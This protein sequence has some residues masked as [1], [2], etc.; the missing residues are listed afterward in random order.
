M[1]PKIKNTAMITTTT[2]TTTT[3]MIN[4]KTF[5]GRQ[6]PNTLQSSLPASHQKLVL[7]SRA[8][9]SFRVRLR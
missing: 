5:P 8:L 6:S 4:G 1:I 7:L 9:K 3:T 2:T